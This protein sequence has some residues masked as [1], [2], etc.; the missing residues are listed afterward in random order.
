MSW[1]PEPNVTG[2]VIR[3]AHAGDRRIS[4]QAST[5][6]VSTVSHPEPPARVVSLR[7][8]RRHAPCGRRADWVEL[9]SGG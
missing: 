5:L 2:R 7:G 3:G 6:R 1:P 8:S 9:V 4:V